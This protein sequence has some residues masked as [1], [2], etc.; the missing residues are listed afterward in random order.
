MNQ[1]KKLVILTGINRGLGMALFDLIIHRK[2][3]SVLGITRTLNQRQEDLLERKY[4]DC[5]LHDF[6]KEPDTIPFDE[7][8]NGYV[9][10]IFINNAFT[11]EPIDLYQ[12]ISRKKLMDS[13]SINILSPLT[14]L[15]NLVKSLRD[16]QSL[17]IINISSGAARKPIKGWSLYCSSKSFNEMFY[18]CL[19]LEDNIE[20]HS[21]DPGVLN[22]KMQAQIRSNSTEDF[23]WVDHFKSLEL[24]SPND[25][26]KLIV[27][28]YL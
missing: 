18:K 17:K 19:D 12:N 26:A 25:V 5:Y 11:I 28:D 4:F 21:I 27:N 8:L 20:T 24:K 9:E 3:F 22:T 6:T 16:E 1:N 10:I 7:F 23:D 2:N 13:I 14:I 15:N